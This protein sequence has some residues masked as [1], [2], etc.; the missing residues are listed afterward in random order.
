VV[1]A[2]LA[3]AARS[4]KPVSP[5]REATIAG[6]RAEARLPITVSRSGPRRRGSGVARAI[7]L[8]MTT[9]GGVID[10]TKL[11]A[12]IDGALTQLL[13]PYVRLAPRD[14]KT[15]AMANGKAWLVSCLRS[16]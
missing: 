2:R 13:T 1:Q 12:I 3:S 7:K 9:N 14:D 8:S 11:C 15:Y 16:F 6:L 10:A 5:E 4:A